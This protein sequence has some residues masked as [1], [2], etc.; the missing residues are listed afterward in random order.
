MQSQ[1]L[2]EL[3]GLE[4]L[5]GSEQVTKDTRIYIQSAVPVINKEWIKETINE[6]L[7]KEIKSSQPINML[8]KF[9]EQPVKNKIIKCRAQLETEQ[10]TII[11][12]GEGIDEYEA[13]SDLINNL[14]IELKLIEVKLSLNK[15]FDNKKFFFSHLI[16][17]QTKRGQ[18][19]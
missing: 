3:K 4:E 7:V 19:A 9:H 5:E 2:K 13:V 1:I 10:N 16:N 14:D 6:F 8:L 11:V 12:S 18:Y 17:N 15:S